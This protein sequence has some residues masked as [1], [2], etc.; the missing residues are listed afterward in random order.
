MPKAL[1]VGLLSGSISAAAAGTLQLKPPDSVA[2]WGAIADATGKGAFSLDAGRL[3]IKLPG[4]YF[5]LWPDGGAVNAPRVLQD[6]DGDFAIEVAVAHIDKA[7]KDSRIAGLAGTTSFH[8]ASL[9]I[10]HDARNFVRFDRTQM[11]RAGQPVTSCYL[12]V[13]RDGKRV[14]E[15]APLVPD[16]P[17]RLR[18]AR[19]G[20]SLRAACS[21]DDGKQWTELAPQQLTLP[22]RVKAG[23]AALNNTTSGNTVTFTGLSIQR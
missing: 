6:V 8:A 23:V 20:S 17:T 18:L 2:G 13:F 7:V 22:A 19:A 12:H 16:R 4:E 15:L 14:A 9:V 1:L 3:T 5:D 10:W 21:T 11:D